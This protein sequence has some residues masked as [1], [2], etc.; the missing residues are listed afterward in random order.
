MCPGRVKSVE[1]AVGEMRERAV[2]A[3][4][5]AEMPVEVPVVEEM[6]YERKCADLSNGCGHRGRNVNMWTY[7]ACS[8]R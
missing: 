8:L 5:C 3:R 6:G 1:E 7:R 4:S 2:R